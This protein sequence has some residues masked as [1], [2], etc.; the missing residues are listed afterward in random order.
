MNLRELVD[1]RLVFTDVDAGS[2][3]RALRSLAEQLERARAIPNADELHAGLLE[4]ERQG[5]T[6]IGRGV[7]IPHCKLPRLDRVVVA[8]GMAPGGVEVGAPDHQRVVLFFLV[9]SPEGSPAAHLQTLAAISKWI[10]G[11]GNLE[12]IRAARTPDQVLACL[13]GQTVGE[14]RG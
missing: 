12:R 9:V 14:A 3:E 8:V 7:A 11:D 10:K 6:A 5:S 2:S 4:R 1:P 13:V